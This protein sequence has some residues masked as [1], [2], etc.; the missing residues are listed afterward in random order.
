MGFG[1]SRGVVKEQRRFATASFPARRSGSTEA[2]LVRAWR[3]ASLNSQPINSTDLFENCL[4]HFLWITSHHNRRR[5]QFSLKSYDSVYQSEHVQSCVMAA[6]GTAK[7]DRQTTA[8]F[9]LRLF[10]KQGSF[11]RKAFIQ[12]SGNIGILTST[13]WT[14]STQPSHGYPHISRYTHGRVAA[15]VSCASYFSLLCQ[16]SYPNRMPERALHFDSYIQTSRARIDRA[17]EDASSPET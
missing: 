3:V 4:I 9:L 16:A 5:F 2:A 6:Q 1:S 13:D 15:C 12:V 7:I 17:R 8:P 10:F 14:S 11:H